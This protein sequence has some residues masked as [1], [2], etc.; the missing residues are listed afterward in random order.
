MHTMI[1]LLTRTLVGKVIGIAV[2][3]VYVIMDYM[4]QT[5]K[6]L[7]WFD[8]GDAVLTLLTLGVLIGA[9]IGFFWAIISKGGNKNGGTPST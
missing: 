3:A 5:D 4:G 1:R 6:R 9:T 7:Y 8:N 2:V